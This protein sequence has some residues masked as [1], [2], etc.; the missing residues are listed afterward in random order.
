MHF[1]SETEMSHNFV[2]MNSTILLGRGFLSGAGTL[3]FGEKALSSGGSNIV[4]KRMLLRLDF[5]ID[6]LTILKSMDIFRNR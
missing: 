4:L 1:T 2:S 5:A 3:T 6:S